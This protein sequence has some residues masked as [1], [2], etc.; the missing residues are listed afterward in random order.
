MIGICW[1][2]KRVNSAARTVKRLINQLEGLKS[3][4]VKV[5]E[6]L[7]EV[8]PQCVQRQTTLT[9]WTVSQRLKE[10]HESLE[11]LIQEL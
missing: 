9:E 5:D 11:H 7:E 6:I 4:L 8:E 10:S 1:K 3:L 2:Y